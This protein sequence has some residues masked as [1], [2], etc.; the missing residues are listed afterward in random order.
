MHI[1]E[2]EEENFKI[3]IFYTF[4]YR[5][6]HRIQKLNFNLFSFLQE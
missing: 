3:N 2:E 4:K 1:E 5:L 6:E